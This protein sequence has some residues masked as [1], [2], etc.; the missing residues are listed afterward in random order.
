MLLHRDVIQVSVHKSVAKT[1]PLLPGTLILT[2]V[3]HRKDHQP[4]VIKTSL[5]LNPKAITRK[6]IA[7]VTRD[8]IISEYA[9]I[10]A[11]ELNRAGIT[12]AQVLATE[13]AHRPESPQD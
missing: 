13:W 11:R 8:A 5:K 2:A 3:V 6:G 1:I 12:N 4:R 9:G 10:V 7:E